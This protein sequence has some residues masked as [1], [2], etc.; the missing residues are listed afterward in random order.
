M[1]L[2][3]NK[4][5]MGVEVHRCDECEYKHNSFE[6]ISGEILPPTDDAVLVW[7]EYFRYGDYNRLYRTMGISYTFNGAWSGFVNGSSGWHELRIIAW[8][9]LPKSPEYQ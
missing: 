2:P 6:W 1:K 4:L 8:H 7:F 9:P 3:A 5:T